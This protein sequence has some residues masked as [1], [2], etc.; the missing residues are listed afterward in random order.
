MVNTRSKGGPMKLIFGSLLGA[1]L[2]AVP[3][4]ADTIS[5]SLS[6][7][8]APGGI[9]N[10][11]WD[12]VTDGFIQSCN[13]ILYPSCSFYHDFLSVSAPSNGGGCGI[14]GV[15]AYPGYAFTTFFSPLCDGAYDSLT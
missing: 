7:E 8:N 6:V 2:L 1:M 9:G 14:T 11:S 3:A 5:Y 12:L 13:D 4:L 10:V 15:F